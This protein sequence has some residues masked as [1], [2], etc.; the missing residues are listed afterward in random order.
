MRTRLY[1][2]RWL[3]FVASCCMQASA[4]LSY[5]FSIYAP[6]LKAIFGYSDTQIASVGSAFNIGGYLAIPSGYLYDR[7]EKHKR[8]GPRF[9]ALVG[10]VILACGYMGLY[11]CTAGLL[12]PSFMLVCFFAL[13][14]GNSSTWF[15]TACVVTN[16]RNFPHDRGTVVG[17]LKAFVGLSASIY[18]S[19]YAAVYSPDPI[20]FLYFVATGPPALAL[21]L[22]CLI[23]LVPEA[24]HEPDALPKPEPQLPAAHAPPPLPKRGAAAGLAEPLLA[25]EDDV[26]GR[27]EA[28]AP[29]PPVLTPTAAGG[30]AKKM[31]PASTTAAPRPWISA[32]TRFSFVYGIVGTVAAYQTAAALLASRQAASGGDEEEGR[33]LHL[34][35]LVGLAV[36]LTAMLAVPLGSGNWVHR[37]P[38]PDAVE[39]VRRRILGALRDRLGSAGSG[40]SFSW[41]LGRGTSR[42]PSSASIGQTA[43]AVQ[44]PGAPS[45]AVLPHP[46][47]DSDVSVASAAGGPAG[48]AAA[49]GPAPGSS[50]GHT[51]GPSRFAAPALGSSAEAA[52]GPATTSAPGPGGPGPSL[53]DQLLGQ[54]STRVDRL[55]ERVERAQAEQQAEAALEALEEVPALPNLPLGEAARSLPFWL[56]L[57]QFSVGLGTG[58]AF[59]NNLGSIVVALGGRPGGQVVFVSL[60]SVANAMGRMLGG[61]LSEMALRRYG[62]PRTFLLSVVSCL[63]LVGVVGAALSGEAH[64]GLYATSLLAGAAF[65][66]HWGLVPAIT[67]DLFGLQYFGSNYTGLQLGPAVGGYVLATLLTGRL[68]DRAAKRHGDT[69]FCL[70]ADCFTDT[71]LVLGALNA[72]AVCTTRLLYVRTRAHYARICS[73]GGV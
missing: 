51:H 70:G 1:L 53:E 41:L 32:R 22:I 31:L 24:Y 29:A 72:L 57:I 59:L 2:N 20:S 67:S 52:R 8:A 3:T 71:W 73:G 30:S 60:F 16:V 47:S 66:A 48:P 58:L 21:V 14:G 36:L 62:T 6:A 49:P 13:L 42:A 44:T 43:A 9:V 54:L 5:S 35:L 61:V 40:G 7:M 4:G 55:S 68:A 38:R 45:S 37:K 46:K 27:P 17:I 28:A 69:G 34:R 18:S 12:E 33:P 26:E 10:A 19:I 50:N 25:T 39:R 65:G 63:T 56:L 64:D 23:N 11:G 15:D